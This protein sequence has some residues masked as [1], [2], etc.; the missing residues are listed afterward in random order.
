L[1]G[2][3]AVAFCLA[4]AAGDHGLWLDVPYVHQEKDGCGSASLAMVLQYWNGKGFAMA[5]DRMDPVT[6]QRELY[7]RKA[8]GIYASEMENYLRD[9]GFEVFA[10]RAEWSDLR[11]QLAK[12]R[13][14]IAGLKP[15]GEPAHYLVVVGIDPQDAAVLV[16]DPGRGKFVRVER[17]EFERAWQGTESWTL[18]AVPRRSSRQS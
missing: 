3:L 2:A 10:F 14:L 12:G 8:R 17:R 7:A 9:S 16:N 5:A 11:S 6:I 15:K 4:A 18:L 1:A 13:P